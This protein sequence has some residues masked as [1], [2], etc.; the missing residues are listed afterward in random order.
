M[1]PAQKV[2]SEYMELSEGERTEFGAMVFGSQFQ[3][4]T[5]AQKSPAKEKLGK[6]ATVANRPVAKVKRQM[7]PEG[8]QR[9]AEATRKRWEEFRANKQKQQAKTRTA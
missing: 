9:I 8:R 2:F 6:P 7:S 4:P 1:T 3:K 5:T